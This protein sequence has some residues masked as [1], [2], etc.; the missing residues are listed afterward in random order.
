MSLIF[1]FLKS[2]LFHDLMSLNVK[3]YRFF[4][5]LINQLAIA[6]DSGE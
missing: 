3:A 5:I 6:F 1:F 4:S 2:S